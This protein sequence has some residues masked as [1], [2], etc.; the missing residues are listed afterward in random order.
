MILKWVSTPFTL[1]FILP[2]VVYIPEPIPVMW[3][4]VS[5]LIH[6]LEST[7]FSFIKFKFDPVSTISVTSPPQ[8]IT[9]FRRTTGSWVR[10]LFRRWRTHRCLVWGRRPGP[11]GRCRDGPFASLNGHWNL[12][13]VAFSR[14]EPHVPHCVFFSDGSL[15]PRGYYIGSNRNQCPIYYDS[16]CWYGSLGC[17]GNRV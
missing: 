8:N 7:A 14:Y 10:S 11:S 6:A 12:I 1:I 3:W 4:M 16:Y 5:R 9:S 13:S 15:V 2:R 17:L